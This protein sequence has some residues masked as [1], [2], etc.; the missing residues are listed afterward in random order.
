MKATSC[1][2]RLKEINS[3]I[4]ALEFLVQRFNGFSMPQRVL[5]HNTQACNLSCPHCSTHGTAEKRKIFNHRRHNMDPQLLNRVANESLPYAKEYSLSVSGEPLVDPKAGRIISELSKYGARMI[6]LTN[7]MLLDGKILPQLMPTTMRVVISMDGGTE[8][9][10]EA[11]R[12]GAKFERVLRNIR[13]LVKTNE[14]L[15]EEAR[16]DTIISF[17]IMGSSIS[18][19]PELVKMTKALGVDKADGRLIIIHYDH[20]ADEAIEHHKARYN[21]FYR[22]AHDLASQIGVNLTLPDAYDEVEPSTEWTPGLEKL[23]LGPLPDNYYKRQP[24]HASY[25]DEEA[26]SAE[27]AELAA[28]IRA[29]VD[30]PPPQAV[31]ERAERMIEDAQRKLDHLMS[32]HEEKLAELSKRPGMEERYCYYLHRTV[33]VR[34]NGEVLACCVPKT[35]VLGNVLDK[36]L[37]DVWSSD[38]YNDFRRRF[39]SKEP[40]EVCRG[41]HFQQ[42]IPRGALLKQVFAQD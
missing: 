33:F 16:L 15:P 8:K 3:R 18:D 6:L 22:H 12:L 35:P 40:P 19:L 4:S 39:F 27:A 9:V 29:F 41:C 42:R 30:T 10:F 7:G 20:L 21:H 14:L 38:E 37:R 23:I 34:A 24:E 11:T 31:R 5:F 17:C 1:F 36:S 25:W 28:R 13:V 32:V 2:D 26:V